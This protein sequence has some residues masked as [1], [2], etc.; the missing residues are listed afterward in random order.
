M[1]GIDGREPS[2]LQRGHRILLLLFLLFFMKRKE[3][4]E[5]VGLKLNIQRT[6]IMAFSPI[7]SCQIVGKQ[8]KQ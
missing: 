7:T 3:E 4:C 6:K 2:G 5:K 1:T 8:W